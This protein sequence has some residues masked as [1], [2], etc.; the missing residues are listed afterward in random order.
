MRCTL[1]YSEFPPIN[2]FKKVLES[3]PQSAI[4]FASLWKLKQK[5]MKVS[6]RKTAINSM[7]L[8]SRTLFRNHLLA[9]GRIDLISFKELED[10]FLI[11]FLDDDGK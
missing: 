7:F 1:N 11:D 8:I 9:L 3:C 2:I 10:D 5:S 4:L 6:I